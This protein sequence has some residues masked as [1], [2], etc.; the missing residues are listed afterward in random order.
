MLRPLLY[1]GAR[2][3]S[4]TAI[5]LLA[6]IVRCPSA[7]AQPADP[8]EFDTSGLEYFWQTVDILASDR[9]LTDVE[10][11]QLLQH[12]GYRIIERMGGRAEAL[13]ACLPVVFQPSR[14][15]ELKN[16]I[17]EGDS[18]TR[19]I[20][21]HLEEVRTRRSELEQFRVEFGT[22]DLVSARTRAAR[23][24]P[25]GAVQGEPPL[26]Y[27]ILFELNGF[28]GEHL[29]LDAMLLLEM[30]PDQ[31]LDFLAHEFHHVYSRRVS[32][33]WDYGEQSPLVGALDGL[34]EE[35]IA[36]LLDKRTWLDPEATS[37]LAPMWTEVTA[38]FRELYDTTPEAL[39][40]I[41]T[42]LRNVA[43][44]QMETVE[45]ARIV[46]RVL[47]W[48]GHARG[49]YMALTIEGE[50]GTRRVAEVSTDPLGFLLAYQAAAGEDRFR[51]SQP[52][53]D[54]LTRL[55]REHVE[56]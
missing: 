7:T 5:L 45:A 54:F 33:A 28:G 12:P 3:A 42:A 50:M 52:A 27:V 26:S 25:A 10:W 2:Y 20:C 53:V 22:E 56:P 18:R 49:M 21:N 17:A 37:E 32:A 46:N 55:R 11:Q 43:A 29:A 36:S 31:R 8:P 1:S 44:G 14:R 19:R 30:T 40:E 39:S 9:D 23:Y 48:G 38:S 47:P 51:F 34:A 13:R 35:G 4:A 16:V 41:D 6:A 24:L 15:S